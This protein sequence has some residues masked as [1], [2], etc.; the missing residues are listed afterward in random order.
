TKLRRGGFWRKHVAR[1]TRAGI[2]TSSLGLCIGCNLTSP[3][4]RGRGLKRDQAGTPGRAAGV[5][6]FTRAWIGTW[7]G[8]GVV[9][10]APVARFTRA[11]IETWCGDGVVLDSPVAR[12]TRAWIETLHQP[13]E[14]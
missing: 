12:F 1:F 6:R 4:S 9:L 3:A 10:D 2:E 5:A 8:D 7:G 14:R 11:W 13:F